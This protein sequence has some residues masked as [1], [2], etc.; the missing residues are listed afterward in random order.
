MIFKR[1]IKIIVTSNETMLKIPKKY[2]HKT[3]VELA[4]APDVK[5][6]VQDQFFLN[7]STEITKLCFAGV[8]EYHKGIYIILK[9]LKKL[10]ENNVKFFFNF[11]GDGPLKKYIQE[12]ILKEN[13]MNNVKLHGVIT[14]K[15]ITKEM[16]KNHI[17]LFPALRDSGG[18]VLFEAMSVGL[19]S[20]I[21]KLGGP[22]NIIDNNCGI[23]ID[24][25]N[26][27]EKNLI[28]EIYDNLINLIQDTDK[29]KKLSN[30]CYSR[31]KLFSWK[32]KIK[33]IYGK[34]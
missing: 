9:I 6:V 7:K 12:F 17:F 13:L 14:K 5:N 27:D 18:F 4:I 25:K 10:K 34:L 16:K 8:F 22:A 1:S 11:Y 31:L 3:F 19:P 15:N 29:L 28:D 21:L 20:L 30:N 2:H 26:K 23:I 32:S 24:T 33:K